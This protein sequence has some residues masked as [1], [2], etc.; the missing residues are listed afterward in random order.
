MN[1]EV[2]TKGRLNNYEAYGIFDGKGLVVKKGS[3]VSEKVAKNVNPVVI[4][5]REK[6]L[7]GDFTTKENVKFRSPSTAAAFVTGNVSNGYRVW[8]VEQGVDLGMYK[9][10]NNGWH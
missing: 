10:K 7:Q 3:R 2:Y 9:E 1:V 5:M 4:K 6:V 8:K